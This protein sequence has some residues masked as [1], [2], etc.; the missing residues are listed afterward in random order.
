MTSMRDAKVLKEELLLDGHKRVV[1]E[2][3]Q[4]TENDIQDWIYLD[5]PRSTMVVA[6]T[7]DRQLLLVKI[8]RHNLKMDACEL[9]AGGVD[10][11]GE[12]ALQAAKRELLEETGFTTTKFID[13][14]KYYALPSQTNRWVQYYLALD[15]TKRQ[16]PQPDNLIEKYFDM[17]VLQVPFKMVQTTEGAKKANITGLESLFGLVLAREYINAI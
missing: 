7:V 17:S 8:Y 16:E 12:T 14:G 3:L 6:L 13:L 5:T 9:P 4:F 1:K 10:H 2:T 15:V 11:E